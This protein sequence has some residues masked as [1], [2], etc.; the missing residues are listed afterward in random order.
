MLVGVL[1]GPL[2]L[3]HLVLA[4]GAQVVHVARLQREHKPCDPSDGEDGVL[5]LDLAATRGWHGGRRGQGG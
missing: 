5:A 4:T 1:S 2:R 3:V